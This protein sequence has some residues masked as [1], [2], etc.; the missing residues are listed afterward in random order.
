MT[1]WEAAVPAIRIATRAA[2]TFKTCIAILSAFFG[3]LEGGTHAR[4]CGRV[5]TAAS[6]WAAKI[7][8]LSVADQDSGA[9]DD[10]PT[11]HDLKC[12]TQKL[13]IHVA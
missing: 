13:C 4:G 3:G 1:G 10:K 5:K 6:R 11:H 7:H 12:G 2:Q 9:K 8:S